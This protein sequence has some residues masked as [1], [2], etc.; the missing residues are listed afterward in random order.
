MKGNVTVVTE[1]DGKK[2]LKILMQN[3]VEKQSMDGIVMI[4]D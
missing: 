4:P 3:M 2:A 1:P